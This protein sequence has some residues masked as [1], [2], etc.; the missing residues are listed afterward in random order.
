[1]KEVARPGTEYP[2]A[3]PDLMYELA[4]DRLA[5]QVLSVDALDGRLGAVVGWGSIVALFVAGVLVFRHSPLNDGTVQFFLVLGGGAYTILLLVCLSALLPR[6][7]LANPNLDQVWREHH[8]LPVH[9]IRWR[10][11]ADFIGFWRLN[12]PHYESKTRKLLTAHLLLV[13][14]AVTALVTVALVVARG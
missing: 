7:W 9:D 3:E 8:R 12:E 6:R 11:A 2:D 10:V 5:V 4:R 14:E 13:A 1:M